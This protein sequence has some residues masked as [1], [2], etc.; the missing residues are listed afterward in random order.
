MDMA[1]LSISGRV[2][3]YQEKNGL[4]RGQDGKKGGAFGALRQL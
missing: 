4:R 3:I 2:C 1:A